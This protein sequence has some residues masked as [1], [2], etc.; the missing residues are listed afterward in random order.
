MR[1]I[2]KRPREPNELL[3]HRK[4]RDAS[5][6]NFEQKDALREPLVRDQ[7]NL[8]CYCMCR[9][10]PDHR[11]MKIE[12]YKCQARY[13]E[14]QLEWRNL[15]AACTGGEGL[16]PQ[17]QTCDT[18]KGD[19]ELT[20]DP[21]EDRDVA[22]L[23]YLPDGRIEY[24]ADGEAHALAIQKDL[25][26]RLNLNSDTL[27]ERRKAALESFKSS[28]VKELGAASWSR[29]KLEQRLTRSRRQRPLPPFFG[30]VEY[31]LEKKIRQRQGQ[32]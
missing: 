29:S 27:K 12:H 32:R 30:A 22:K 3:S 9:I 13:P 19:T 5:Y 6:D 4:S 11:D 2:D 24:D 10:K 14:F 31:W 20:I 25:D 23:K 21:R 28:L 16:P 7:G 8:C 17:H 26:L 18:S 1:R 15:L